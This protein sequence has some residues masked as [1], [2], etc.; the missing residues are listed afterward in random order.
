MNQLH[1]TDTQQG[2]T[3][4]VFLH[5]F[6]GSGHTWQPVID[7][8]SGNYR[9]IAIDL[10]GFGKSPAP[11]EEP[12]VHQ[13]RDAVLAVLETLQ[14]KNFTLV[15][16]SMGG[17]IA[18]AVAAVQP[19]GLQSMVLFA[20]SPPTAEPMTPDVRQELLDAFGNKERIEQH[21]QKI[22]AQP[23]LPEWMN[24]TVTDNLKATEK[25]W[26]GWIHK[27]SKEDISGEAGNIQVPVTVVSGS[28]DE[29]LTTDFLQ[30]E[31]RK[32]FPQIFFYRN[33]K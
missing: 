18:V 4:I 6:G 19:Q 9:C 33:R 3:A 26:T 5:Y 23:L 16:H 7:E 20:P 8:L 27:G 30:T 21:I 11:E 10:L 17:K 25:A 13:N 24:E 1:Y 14:L 28:K 15:G 12:S 22:V 2:N 31:F 32:Y 29:G